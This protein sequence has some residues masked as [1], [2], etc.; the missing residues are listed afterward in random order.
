MSGKKTNLSNTINI[1]AIVVAVLIVLIAGGVFLL[2][3]SSKNN[4]NV[5]DSEQPE[6]VVLDENV[7]NGIFAV[8]SG[9]VDTNYVSKEELDSYNKGAVSDHAADNSGANSGDS[10]TT[11]GT[12]EGETSEAQENKSETT[13][14]QSAANQ[15]GQKVVVIDAGHQA[16]G[17]NEKEPVGPG[18]TETKAK[19]TTGTSGVSTGLTEALLNLSVAL[20]LQTELEARGYKVIMCRTT[21]DVNMS[22]SERAQIANDANADAFIR[23]HANGSENSSANGAMTICQTSSNPYNASLHDKSYSLSEKVL[24]EL[25]ASTGC[26]KERIWET[27]TMS[28]INWCSVPVTIV[29]MGYMSNPDED[30][31]LASDD[32]QDLIVSGIANGIDRFFT[33]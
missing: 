18:A 6:N 1:I 22:N 29:E 11:E 14:G 28:G 2:L 15:N 12:T 23:I 21:N 8:G 20:K 5:A 30:K 32:Y 9:K 17:N 10:Q 31:K 3:R 24:D 26:K 19:V 16:K 33:E 25:V 13:S 4:T 27:D 7:I